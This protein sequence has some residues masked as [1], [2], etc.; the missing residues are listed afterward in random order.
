MPAALL[1]GLLEF[2]G[3]FAAAIDLHGSDGEWHPLLEAVEELGGRSSGRTRVRLQNVRAR[4]DIARGEMFPD[5]A[6]QRS[7]VGHIDLDEITGLEGPIMFGFPHRVE[8]RTQRTTRATCAASERLDQET[9]F[10]QVP[11]D[12]PDHGRGSTQALATGEHDQLV[13]L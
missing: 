1:P 11:Q 5:H 3:E 4:D 8:A 6:G 2:S 10:L 13:L 9:A 12:A 7:H